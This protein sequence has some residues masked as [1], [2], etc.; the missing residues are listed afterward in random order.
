MAPCDLHNR[1]QCAEHMQG[2]DM[3]R[4]HAAQRPHAAPAGPS[5]HP[6]PSHPQV[7]LAEALRDEGAPVVGVDLC[8]NP[9]VGQWAT[10]LPALQRAKAAGLKITLHAGVWLRRGASGLGPVQAR[11]LC[12]GSL[13]GWAQH[14]STLGARMHRLLDESP[15]HPPDAGHPFAAQPRW[16]RTRRRRQ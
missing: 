3:C 6:S 11:D 2:A 15:T 13:R 10:W 1:A 12:L 14:H 16:R 9:A 7:A 4:V 8:G 5:T